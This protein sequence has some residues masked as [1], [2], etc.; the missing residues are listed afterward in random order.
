M[1][2]DVRTEHRQNKGLPKEAFETCAGSDASW[3]LGRGS[4]HD[5]GRETP[6]PPLVSGRVNFNVGVRSRAT[7]SLTTGSSIIDLCR[8]ATRAG[9]QLGRGGRQTMQRAA[10][11][12]PARVTATRSVSDHPK[13]DDRGES[14]HANRQN[15]PA[16]DPRTHCWDLRVHMNRAH[17]WMRWR[18]SIASQSAPVRQCK[19]PVLQ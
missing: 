9:R 1:R 5:P 14:G 2:L 13:N 3:H 4:I 10:E 8:I 6:R 17:S 16:T 11:P 15:K 18:I 7:T 19:R 12:R